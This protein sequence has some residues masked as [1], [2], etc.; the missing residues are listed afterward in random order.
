[1]SIINSKKTSP[2]K[3]TEK[4]LKDLP[5]N[6]SYDDIQYHLYVI[7]KV[8]KGLKDADEGNTYSTSQVRSKFRKWVNR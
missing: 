2:K 1:M 4:L 7:Q 8:E 5:E 3:N 6:C